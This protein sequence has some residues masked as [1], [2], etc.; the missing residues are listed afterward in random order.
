MYLTYTDYIQYGGTLDEVP[1]NNVCFE[2]SS[3][4]DWYTFDR[5]SSEQY[6]SLPTAV[7]RCT[8]NLV[9]LITAKN[10]ALAIT[11]ED[12]TPS[13]NSGIVSSES[14][15]GVSVSYNILTSQQFLDYYS[16]E[17][18]KIIKQ[19]LTSVTNSLG[20]KVLY[21]GFYSGE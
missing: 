19:Y 11:S 14:N 8:Y 3:I 1:F 7:K 6:D 20:R 17:I 4:I 15:D 12:E 9:Q 21:R 16:Q 13:Q 5:L 18:G 2:A 10:R